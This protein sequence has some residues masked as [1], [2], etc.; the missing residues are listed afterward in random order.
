LRE[1]GR[2]RKRERGKEELSRKGLEKQVPTLL[3]LLLHARYVR[4]IKDNGDAR[5]KTGIDGAFP[6]DGI[7]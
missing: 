6:G 2:E 1:S 5:G 7:L 4:I 3:G